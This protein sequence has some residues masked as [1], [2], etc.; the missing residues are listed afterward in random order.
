[1]TMTRL[2]RERGDAG[3]AFLLMVPAL[4]IV[5]LSLVNATQGLYER[6]EAWAVAS[7][8]SRVGAQADPFQV[9]VSDAPTID[10]GRA[11]AA[12]RQYVTDEGYRLNSAVFDFADNTLDIEIEKDIGYIFPF[13]VGMPD[14]IEGKSFTT[15][16]A[17]VTAEGT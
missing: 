11:R 5:A 9:R 4:L 1:M 16:R 17:G 15:L 13:H 2:E 7:A 6:R 10:E 12:I 14:T 8:A 3:L